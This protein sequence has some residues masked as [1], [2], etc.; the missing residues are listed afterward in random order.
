MTTPSPR[1]QGRFDAAMR[2]LAELLVRRP[3]ATLMAGLLVSLALWAGLP[4][5]QIQTATEDLIREGIGRF[6]GR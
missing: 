5:I 6:L 1:L 3:W 4:R 2:R